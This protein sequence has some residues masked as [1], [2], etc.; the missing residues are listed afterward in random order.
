MVMQQVNE[1]TPLLLPVKVHLDGVIDDQVSGANRINPLWVAA[2]FHH[3]ITHGSEVH[4]GRNTTEGHLE[5][6]LSIY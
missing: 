4:H 5:Y 6:E 3:S 2:Q 1:H